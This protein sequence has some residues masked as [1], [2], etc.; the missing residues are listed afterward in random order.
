MTT[1][2][3]GPVRRLVYT[4]KAMPGLV[5]DDLAAILKT[6]NSHNTASG[7]TGALVFYMGCF[8]QVIEGAPFAIGALM[9]SI[10]NDK[11]HHDIVVQC[12]VATDRKRFDRWVMSFVGMT[13]RANSAILV[14]E[15]NATRCL[16]EGPHIE[17]LANRLDDLF[18]TTYRASPAAVA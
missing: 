16:V 14:R 8:V 4:S 5:E 6:S 17:S 9:D 15:E 1:N 3:S 11:R 18:L 13:Q 7:I 12:D 2:L 10:A